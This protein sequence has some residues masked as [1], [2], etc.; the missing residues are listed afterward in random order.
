MHQE[1]PAGAL[2][3]RRDKVAQH[4]PQAGQVL[5]LDLLVEGPT[6]SA[7]FGDVVDEARICMGSRLLLS[8]G[9]ATW[10]ALEPPDLP[11][12]NVRHRSS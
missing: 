5:G 11:K 6:S 3:L 2:R 12:F 8:A 10:Q 1:A 7:P 4:I 9:P